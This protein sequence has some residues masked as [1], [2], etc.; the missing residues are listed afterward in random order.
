M[1]MLHYTHATFLYHGDV[2]AQSPT[3]TVHRDLLS[4][5]RLLVVTIPA[6]ARLSHEEYKQEKRPEK[7]MKN[8]TK[9]KE[10]QHNPKRPLT[11]V[12]Q[13]TLFLLAPSFIT[14]PL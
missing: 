1:M 7:T 13:T 2:Y 6:P 14:S 9:K 8:R 10:K 11:R 3:F 5:R 4:S 12:V